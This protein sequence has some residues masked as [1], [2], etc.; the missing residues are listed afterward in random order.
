VFVSGLTGEGLDGLIGRI[1]D[2]AARGS[3]TLTVLVPYTRGDLVALAHERG[4][5]LS[6]RH[7]DDG[8]QLALR[9]SPEISPSFEPFKLAED[10]D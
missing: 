3:V 8:T 7:T 1:A 10:V 2:E 6:E 5:I 9:V 4:Q